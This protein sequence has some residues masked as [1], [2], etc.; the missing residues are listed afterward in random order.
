[1]S[2]FLLETQDLSFAKTPAELEEKVQ[3]LSEQA[4]QN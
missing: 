2:L 4:V 1:M 3:S